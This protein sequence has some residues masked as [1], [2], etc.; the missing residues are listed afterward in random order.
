MSAMAQPPPKMLL[1]ASAAGFFSALAAF[2]AFSAGDPEALEI[3]HGGRERIAQSCTTGDR[4]RCTDQV[5]KCFRDCDTLERCNRTCC[6][7]FHDCL[8]SHECS[9]EAAIC[10]GF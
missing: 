10:Q 2:A 4:D 3:A 7:A 5:V 6:R 8:S 9:L 1:C